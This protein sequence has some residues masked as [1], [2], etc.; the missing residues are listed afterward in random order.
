MAFSDIT[1]SELTK[2]K[3][4][5]LPE[6]VVRSERKFERISNE[7]YEYYGS[8][9]FIDPFSDDDMYTN[10]ESLGSKFLDL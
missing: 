5:P 7:D 1:P 10:Y 3:L 4:P 8:G 9:D 6:P 2:F